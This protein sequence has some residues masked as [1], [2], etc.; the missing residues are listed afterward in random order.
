MKRVD[1]Q[2]LSLEGCRPEVSALLPP[3]TPLHEW[4][5]LI[6]GNPYHPDPSRYEVPRELMLPDRKSDEPAHGSSLPVVRRT[7]CRFPPG[8]PRCRIERE[9]EE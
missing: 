8:H 4:P 1:D 9:R 3:P 5:L 7:P 6:A 2:L